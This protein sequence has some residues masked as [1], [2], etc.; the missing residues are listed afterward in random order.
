M[1]SGLLQFG[2]CGVTSSALSHTP[3]QDSAYVIPLLSVRF[4]KKALLW[5]GSGFQSWPRAIFILVFNPLKANYL[6]SPPQGRTILSAERS[7]YFSPSTNFKVIQKH[8][9]SPLVPKGKGDPVAIEVSATI[10]VSYT[11]HTSNE[12]SEMQWLVIRCVSNWCYHRLQRTLFSSNNS[13]CSSV[14]TRKWMERQSHFK[15]AQ[16][17]THIANTAHPVLKL[18]A[19]L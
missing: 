7:W 14:I 18:D 10:A 4:S 3:L 17:T 8:M 13:L 15:L 9:G 19:L 12:A 2:K 1:A 6:G 16:N 5:K 11:W